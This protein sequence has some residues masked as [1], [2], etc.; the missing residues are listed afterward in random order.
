MGEPTRS[1]KSVGPP[2]VWMTEWKE[3]FQYRNNF[4]SYRNIGFNGK[5]FNAS[6]PHHQLDQLVLRR[7]KVEGVS[8]AV[9]VCNAAP[10]NFQTILSQICRD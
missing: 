6:P 3:G 7:L 2:N 5:I 10:I 8:P 9:G 4:L 1:L